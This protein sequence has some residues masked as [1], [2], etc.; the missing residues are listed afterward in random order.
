MYMEPNI[1]PVGK[2]QKQHIEIARDIAINLTKYTVKHLYSL[3]LQ[4]E[5]NNRLPGLM[6]IR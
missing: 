3:N 6:V 1:V 4:V 5:E 2:D